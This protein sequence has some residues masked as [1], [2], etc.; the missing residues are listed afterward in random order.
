M[1]H[2]RL[3]SCHWQ[4]EDERHHSA[5]R[6]ACFL[7]VNARRR[8]RSKCNDDSSQHARLAHF[9]HRKFTQRT[10]SEKHLSKQRALLGDRQCCEIVG[11]ASR[12]A[13]EGNEVTLSRVF[14]AR[15]RCANATANIKKINF[16]RV[17]C[18]GRSAQRCK[19]DV[20]GRERT[21][22]TKSRVGRSV[23]SELPLSS[24]QFSVCVDEGEQT[25]DVDREELRLRQDRSRGCADVNEHLGADENDQIVIPSLE[26]MVSVP[27]VRRSALTQLV[28]WRM[29]LRPKLT[30]SMEHALCSYSS[31]RMRMSTLT[32]SAKRSREVHLS[33]NSGQRW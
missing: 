15:V 29:L 13:L 24:R 12:Q 11:I 7:A 2:C 25:G 19:S 8:S 33:G 1:E 28:S 3:A 10:P 21:P 27:R 32:R 30:R 18:H 20:I 31:N 4:A 5:V 16:G 9:P 23:S 14:V 17:S 6:S 26:Q 22:T